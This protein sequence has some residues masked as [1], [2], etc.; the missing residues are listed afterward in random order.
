MTYV[1]MER[2]ISFPEYFSVLI[3]N[4]ASVFAQRVRFLRFFELT[5]F[6]KITNRM[7]KGC[8]KFLKGKQYMISMRF[9]SQNVLIVLFLHYFI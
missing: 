9:L 2:A 7:I 8:K 1:F 4:L 5:F 6:L 3:Q